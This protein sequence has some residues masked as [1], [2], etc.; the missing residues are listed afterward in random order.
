MIFFL[1]LKVFTCPIIGFFK[2]NLSAQTTFGVLNFVKKANMLAKTYDCVPN[3]RCI[4]RSM[5]ASQF[6]GATFT[7]IF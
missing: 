7:L 3:F 5:K 1:T 6:P 4:L 2:S